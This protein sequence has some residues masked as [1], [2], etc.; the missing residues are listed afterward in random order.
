M[1]AR[2]EACE[3]VGARVHLLHERRL[4]I[5]K[6]LI[7]KNSMN[8]CDDLCRSQHVLQ[9]RLYDHRIDTAG[10]QRNGMGVS[11]QLGHLAAVKV[12]PDDFDVL[13]AGVKSVQPVADRA[14]PDD[15]H[16]ARPPRK[17]VEQPGDTAFG[18]PIDR[19]PDALQ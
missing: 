14:T 7:G 15:K 19:L 8:L 9:N 2:G 6:P 17:H 10:R 12:H 13:T 5:H 11:D 4:G 16:A 18:D 3:V 1:S